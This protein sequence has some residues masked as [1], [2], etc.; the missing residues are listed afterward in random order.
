MQ[1]ADTVRLGT[2][3]SRLALI[4]A[5]IVKQ[6]LLSFFPDLS[7][8]VIPIKTQGDIDK[9]TPLTQMGGKSVF[10]KELDSALVRG[11]V[12]L[13]VHSL[14]DVTSMMTE[15]V[16]LA[17]FLTPE[18]I[19]DAWVFSEGKTPDLEKPGIV[20][21]T[22]SKRREALVRHFYPQAKVRPI[23]GNVETRLAKLDSGEFDAVLLSHA[24]LIRLGLEERVSQLVDPHHFIPA[25]GQGVI[26]LGARHD[27]TDLIDKLK[28]ISDTRQQKLSEMEL[29]L[30]TRCGFSCQDP[31]GLYA[32]YGHSGI[33]MSIFLG[34]QDFSECL[35]ETVDMNSASLESVAEFVLKWSH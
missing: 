32:C 27:D 15:G 18:S 31:L 24:G 16:S 1:H 35:F 8:D 20:V 28:H 26:A 21:G 3:G 30:Q 9:Q 12:D 13:V 29:A 2:R 19:V 6:K 22:S 10:V 34:R 4:Q 7:V 25:P 14:K 11:D 23:R 33:T 5:D 17:G